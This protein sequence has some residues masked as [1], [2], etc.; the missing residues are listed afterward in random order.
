M[1]HVRRDFFDLYQSAKL[2]VADEAVLRIRQLY[3]VETQTRFQ[4][5]SERM[6]LRQEY[7]MRSLTT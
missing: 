1:A 2:P 3:D 5:A 6:A 7:A 4:P